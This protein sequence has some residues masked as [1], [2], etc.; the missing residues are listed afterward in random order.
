MAL[1]SVCAYACVVMHSYMCSCLSIYAHLPFIS[2]ASVRVCVRGHV[3]MHARMFVCT[4]STCVC[5]GVQ[6]DDICMCVY[7]CA[8]VC[9]CIC[10]DVHVNVC[11][12][13][14]VFGG[15]WLSVFVHV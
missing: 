9:T 14:Y 6:F 5:T 12:Y 7:V 10:M 13:V 15:G 2:R 1:E 3:R 4:H 11:I 8:C